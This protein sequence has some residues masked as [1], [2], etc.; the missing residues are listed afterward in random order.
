MCN[1]LFFTLEKT[2]FSCFSFYKTIQLALS[3][4][5]SLATRNSPYF[6]SL[7]LMQLLI[8]CGLQQLLLALKNLAVLKVQSNLSYTD[9]ERTERSFRI[10]EVSAY[11]R[12]HYDDV[13]FMTPVT[14]LSVQY[15]KPGP[16]SS[17]S[18]IL[19]Y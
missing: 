1:L 10:R 15:L 6:R 4:P 14:V 12:G 3:P 7:S 9:A 17:L 13:T 2:H 8:I 11:K 16:P 18:G 5:L 19:S